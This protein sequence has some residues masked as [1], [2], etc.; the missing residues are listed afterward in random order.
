MNQTPTKYIRSNYLQDLKCGFDESSPYK[1]CFLH[2]FRRNTC[3]LSTSS[4]SPRGKEEKNYLPY[5]EKVACPLLSF[6]GYK[7][8][9]FLRE[10]AWRE[11]ASVFGTIEIQNI[12]LIQKTPSPQFY[13]NV[14]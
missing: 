11:T 6:Y 12:L 13:R 2:F 7:L 8:S 9:S 10:V 14:L 1:E 3:P 5:S 4:I